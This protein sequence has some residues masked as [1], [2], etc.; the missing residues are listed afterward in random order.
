MARVIAVAAAGVLCLGLSGGTA[1]TSS[2]ARST[3]AAAPRPNIVV[4]LTDDQDASVE[5]MKRVTSLL[6]NQGLTFDN[7]FVSTPMCAPSRATLLTG[8]YAHN[9]ETFTNAG[10]LGGFERFRSLGRESAT[11]AT[12]LQAAGYRT[13][14]IGKYLN[15]YPG[16]TPGSDRSY[17]P[18]GWD[19]WAAFF[20]PDHTLPYWDY[21]VNENRDVAYYPKRVD[22]YSTDDMTRRALKFIDATERADDQPFFLF[23]APS[24]PHT[25]ADPAPRHE[26]TFSGYQAPRV[27][28]FN[29][30]DM[31]DKPRYYQSLPLLDE[32]DLKKMDKLYRARQESLQA[33]D[34]MLE[35]LLVR[36]E[37]N[38][39]LDHTYVFYTSDNGFL[40]GQHR[41]PQGKD[42]PYEEALRVPLLVRGPG[43][44]AGQRREHLVVN[45]DLPATWLDLAG[46][47]PDRALDGRSLLPLLGAAP[48][49]D[50]AWRGDFLIEHWRDDNDSDGIPGYTG[51]RTRAF[52]YL[53]Y[54]TGER[55]LY[56]M[57]V[58]RDENNNLVTRSDQTAVLQQL[59]ARLAQVRT[60]QGD[61]CR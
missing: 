22:D 23:I 59:A 36:L 29:E 54:E 58:D 57:E 15:R 5:H 2:T 32:A 46:A 41:F 12:W 9:H 38:G 16:D 3:A 31:S 26:G 33:V 48:L 44:A 17:V 55:E 24:T 45:A 1:H 19:Y 50:S 53:E 52:K 43:V 6:A 10:G 30:E 28:A 56:S 60:C 35:E 13:A 8:L 4:I 61:A 51:L 39:E 47:K 25:P 40:Q 11:V 37:A 18:A 14:L 27:G 34:D 42:A 49:P 7:S 20:A 21:M